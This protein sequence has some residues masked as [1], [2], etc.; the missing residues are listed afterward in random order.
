MSDLPSFGGINSMMSPA[1]KFSFLSI[2]MNFVSL[3][4]SYSIVY[5]LFLLNPTMP[6]MKDNPWLDVLKNFPFLMILPCLIKSLS[7]F[8][9]CGRECLGN[10]SLLNI[11]FALNCV[12]G[13][14]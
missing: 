2:I 13:F 4:S 9:I 7:A 5:C 14:F 3:F 10:L 12:S 1:E 8:L 11:T 6:F